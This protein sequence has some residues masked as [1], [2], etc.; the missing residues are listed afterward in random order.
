MKR[1]IIMLFL[2]AS[3]IQS[4]SQEFYCNV[5]VT[6]K[7]IQSSDKRIYE[8]MRNAIYEFMNNRQWTNYNYKFNEKLECSIL[9]NVVERASTE[10]FRCEMTIA[11]RRPVFN[12]NYNSPLFNFID[13]NVD[14]EYIENQPLDFNTG[15]FS[16]NLTSILAYYAYIMLGLDFD[17]FQLNGGN[18]YYEAAL[19]IV[20]AA[21]TSSY[22][23]WNSAEG[24]KNR[25]WLVENLTNPAYTGIRS[26][27]YDYHMKGLDIMYEKPEEGRK[28]IL[29]SLGYLQQVKQ[30]RPG[31]FFLQIISDAK[32]DEF[33]NVFSE[34]LPTE[35][36]NAVKILNELD[37]SNAMTY[38][39]I[40]QN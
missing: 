22:T 19:S 36:T 40:I 18:P 31:L 6:S 37:P 23:G 8:S 26:F 25:F 7:Q 3:V 32:R 21:S 33:V 9:I 10:L 27:Y 28:A 24:N 15:T 4:Y 30:S 35:K 39:K 17:T 29:Q 5:D 38:Q 16:S 11:S 12:S 14:F 2:L 1:I 20:N 34:G 13:K